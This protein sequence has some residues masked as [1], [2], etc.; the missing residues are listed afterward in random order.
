MIYEGYNIGE[1]NAR[2]FDFDDELKAGSPGDAT[3]VRRSV[4]RRARR[5][6]GGCAT[7]R[8]ALAAFR[9]SADAARGG[10]MPLTG[11]LPA[12]ALGDVNI[13][14]VWRFLRAH[15]IYTRQDAT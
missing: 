15:A 2:K 12:R 4:A 11:R 9:K 13:Q 10:N 5:R 6:S 1:F 8:T 7:T 14:Y 3:I